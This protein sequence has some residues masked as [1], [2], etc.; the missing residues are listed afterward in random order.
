MW[1]YNRRPDRWKDVRRIEVKNDLTVNFGTI[2][3]Q[4]AAILDILREQGPE[5]LQLGAGPIVD[6]EV[7]ERDEPA[8]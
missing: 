5:A 7:V 3:A 6:A 2:A 4:K 8:A 1:L